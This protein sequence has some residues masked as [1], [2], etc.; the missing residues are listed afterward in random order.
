MSAAVV[1]ATSI[2]LDAAR[3][4]AERETAEDEQD[5][6][7]HPRASASNPPAPG[8]PAG[9]ASRVR[10]PRLMLSAEKKLPV[11]ARTVLAV[12]FVQLYAGP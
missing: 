12:G 1:E 11:T 3:H 8:S 2:G 4:E 9:P 6:V 5:R 7:R 10:K